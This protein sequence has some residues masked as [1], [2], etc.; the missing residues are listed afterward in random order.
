[1]NYLHGRLT[2]QQVTETFFIVPDF[3]IILG[4]GSSYFD[5]FS[6]KRGIARATGGEL[7]MIGWPDGSTVTLART[8]S[9]DA[10]DP[11]DLLTLY[12]LNASFNGI[13]EK[14]GTADGS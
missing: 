1:M 9:S 2:S 11:D 5:T 12:R 3:G 13:I 4:Y 6:K 14:K 8:N 10:L 7:N